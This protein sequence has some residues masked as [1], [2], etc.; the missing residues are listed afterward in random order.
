MKFWYQLFSDISGQPSTNR[1]LAFFVVVVPL[2][3]WSWNVISTNNWKEPSFELI[4]MIMAGLGSK[5]IQRHVEQ[6]SQECKGEP[7]D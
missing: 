2:L 3:T 5:V 4:G 7:N 6:K 1:L